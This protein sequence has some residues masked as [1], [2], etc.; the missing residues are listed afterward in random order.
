MSAEQERFYAIRLTAGDEIYG[1]F[2]WM[3]CRGPDDWTVAE[4][5]DHDQPTE[6]EIVQ[7]IVVPIAKRTFGETQTDDDDD[8]PATEG[9]P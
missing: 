1:E 6:Y 7:M 9:A 5:S 3:G 4:D 2:A 8:E